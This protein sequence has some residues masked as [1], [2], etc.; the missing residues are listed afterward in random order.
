MPAKKT[1]TNQ[2]LKK[3][4]DLREKNSENLSKR[5]A[6]FKTSLANTLKQ[7]LPEYKNSSTGSSS[8]TTDKKVSYIVGA[9]QNY[10]P[11]RNIQDGMFLTRDNRFIGVIEILPIGFYQKNTIQINSL[12]ASFRE[13]FLNKHI[14]WMIK[15]MRDEGDSTELISHLRRNCPDQG[16]PIINKSL[17]NYISFLKHLATSGTIAERY[18]FIWEY[19]GSNG[20]KSH[21]PD[22]IAE[23]MLENKAAIIQSIEDCGN[24]CLKHDNENMA[25]SEFAYMFFNRRTYKTE[26]IYERYE[27]ISADFERF[28]QVTGLNK[29]ISYADL[30]APKGLST[31]NKS[32]MVIDGL[33]YGFIGLSSESWPTDVPAG[34]LDYIN[35]GANV[36]IDVIGKLQPHELSFATLKQLNSAT[37]FNART[38]LRKGKN[39]KAEKKFQRF[40]DVD[41]LIRSLEAGD[42]IYD[43]AIILTVRATSPK[44]LRSAMRRISHFLRHKRH[45]MPDSC[46][47]CCEDY[48]RLTM[49]FLYTTPVFTRLKHNVLATKLG[50]FYPFTSLSLNDPNGALLGLSGNQVYSMDLFNNTLLENANMLILGSSGSGKTYTEQLFAYRSFF[51]G[52]RCFL[53]LPMKGYEYKRSCELTDGLYVPLM[54]GSSACINILEIRPEGAINLSMLTKDTVIHEQS[55]LAQKISTVITWLELTM[56]EASISDSLSDKLSTILYEMYTD[57]G[58]TDNNESIYADSTHTTLKVMP[59][60]SDLYHYIEKSS[61]LSEQ[62][63]GRLLSTLNQFIS[64]ISKNLNGQTNVDLSKRYIA[65]DCDEKIIGKKLLASYLYIAY[66]FICNAVKASPDSQDL[67]F[68]D[69]VWRMMRT[70]SCAEQI[71]ELVKII[72]GYYGGVI[73]A[74][75]EINDFLGKMPEFGASVIDCCATTLLL[76]MK[77]QDL[78]LVKDNYLLTN[79]EFVHVVKQK[80]HRD[81]L[82]LSGNDRIAI[83]IVSSIYE[84]RA[85]GDRTSRRVA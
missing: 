46:Y 71:Q 79:D 2:S 37:N 22:E 17:Q 77:P 53:L 29:S 16:N 8:V 19:S 32:Y 66:Q 59:I 78:R 21:D 43:V 52:K 67:I 76:K 5:T 51:N 28:N 56:G 54:P 48:Y 49:P 36:D 7:T 1:S 73:F 55:L 31:K 45:I 47:T 64:G 9:S 68:L 62:D 23:T 25:L 65:F 72:R 18:Y 13:V 42:D 34:W 58:I 40:A 83:Q 11:L 24:I 85:L 63:A 6:A 81:G 27:R 30:I 70:A 3:L 39:E 26:S 74:T 84:E 41:E 10:I 33:Y 15:I 35:C 60:L 61:I 14:R 20:I 38:A 82:L 80:A 4:L 50:Y 69:E 75:Q 12:I 57:F 44:N